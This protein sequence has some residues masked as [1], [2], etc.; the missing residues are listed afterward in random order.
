MVNNA[1]D[2]D[3]GAGADGD[4]VERWWRKWRKT[5]KAWWSEIQGDEG[6]ADDAECACAAA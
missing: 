6:V 2:Q 3:G 5:V 4:D 1:G